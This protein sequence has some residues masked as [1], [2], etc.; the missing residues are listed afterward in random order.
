MF[1]RVLFLSLIATSAL[2]ND[3]NPIFTAAERHAREITEGQGEIVVKAGPLDTSRL[4]ECS[5]L[6]AYTPPNVRPL[7][8]SYVGVRCID[9]ANWNILVPVYIGIIGNYIASTRA[10][11]AGQT[12]QATDISAMTGDLTSLPQDAINAAEDAVGKTLRNSI[13]A[14]QALRSNQLVS[15]QI[16]RRGQ[17]VKVIAKGDGFIIKADGKAL[18][19]AAQ[20]DVANVKMQSG[21]TIS[22]IVQANGTI[23]LHN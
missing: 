11:S 6:E 23:L 8:R 1:I 21:R 5:R 14:G 10:L 12:I 18:N 22:G 2:A 9:S 20:G 19:N 16:I 13:N 7:G 3:T 4:A 17:N 15:P